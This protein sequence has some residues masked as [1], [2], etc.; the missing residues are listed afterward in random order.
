MLRSRLTQ[1]LLLLL[2]SSV[3]TF[4]LNVSHAPISVEWFVSVTLL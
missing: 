4:T 3:C 2:R 1:N